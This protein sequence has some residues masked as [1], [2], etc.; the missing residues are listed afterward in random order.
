MRGANGQARNDSADQQAQY[1]PVFCHI[2]CGN[3][4]RRVRIVARNRALGH[5]QL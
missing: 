1:V 2:A 5:I 4:T 3:A